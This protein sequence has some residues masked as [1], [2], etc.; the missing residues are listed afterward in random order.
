[1]HPA[2]RLRNL[3]K[4]PMSSRRITTAV[5]AAHP[6]GTAVDR[7]ATTFIANPQQ[8]VHFLPVHHHLLDP[9]RIPTTGELD[10]Y[11][12]D[13][14]STVYAASVAVGTIVGLDIPPEVGV[15]FWPRLW[16]WVDFLWTFRDFLETA[17]PM[18]SGENLSLGLVTFTYRLCDYAPN[19][20]LVESTPGFQVFVVRAWASLIE[21]EDFARNVPTPELFIVHDLLTRGTVLL[22]ERIEGAGGGIADLARLV[23]THIDLVATGEDEPLSMDKASLLQ[24][25]LDIVLVT[26]GIGALHYHP[27]TT[28]AFS[29]EFRASL[30]CRALA[31]ASLVKTLTINARNLSQMKTPAADGIATKCLEVL[32]VIFKF[33]RGFR[34]LRVAIRIGLIPAILAHTQRRGA[35]ATHSFYLQNTLLKLLTQILIPASVHYHV[36]VDLT[37]AFL[38]ATVNDEENDFRRPDVRQAWKHFAYLVEIRVNF[39][40]V[41]DSNDYVTR[42]ACDNVKCGIILQKS[43]LSRCSGCQVLLY[44]SRDCQRLDWDS[45]H[46]ESCV[47]Y[48]SRRSTFRLD[49]TSRESAFMRALIHNDYTHMRLQI[50]KGCVEH[51]VVRPEAQLFVLFDYLSAGPQISVHIAKEDPTKDAIHSL[52]WSDLAARESRSAGRI[53]LHIMRVYEGAGQLDTVILLRRMTSKIPNALKQIAASAGS[54]D[55]AQVEEQIRILL[56]EDVAEDIH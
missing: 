17:I 18:P 29:R 50:Y 7:F 13:L 16:K 47:W 46:R 10:T 23:M 11:S 8:L 37:T 54:F 22:E 4:L 51:W 24:T 39:L 3:D 26:D 43:D 38:T 48:L 9:A 49:Y 15:D 36:L 28:M 12:L 30:L 55:P 31:S 53:A 5:C 42:R 35:I 45:G 32:A 34:L 14:L 6:S 33:S 20:A 27:E 52:Y 25:V 40:R 21:R 1:M 56:E 44:C 41:F 2:L 19:R